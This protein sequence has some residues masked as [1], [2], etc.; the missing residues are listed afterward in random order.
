M[1]AGEKKAKTEKN[2]VDLV[3]AT[4]TDV[5]SDFDSQTSSIVGLYTGTLSK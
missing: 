4:I 3:D 5:R 2:S 1:T